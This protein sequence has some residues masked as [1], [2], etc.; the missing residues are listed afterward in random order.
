MNKAYIIFIC[1]LFVLGCSGEKSQNEKVQERLTMKELQQFTNGKRLYEQRCANCHMADGNGLGQLI[2][3]LNKSDY[4]FNNLA[5]SAQAMKDGLEGQISVNGIN[6]NQPMPANSDLTNSE[7]LE[8]M[9]Y[10]TNAWENEYTPSALPNILT[11]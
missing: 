1:C 9:I 5:I 2:P 11:Q 3:P 6:Y 8:I 7:I 10:I 4:L